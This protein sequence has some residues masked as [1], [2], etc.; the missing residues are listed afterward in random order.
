MLAQ[1]R[2]I[3][4][5]SLLA[6]ALVFIFSCKSALTPEPNSKTIGQIAADKLGKFNSYPSPSATNS[7]YVQ[8]APETPAAGILKFVVIEIESQTI[9]YEGSFMPGYVKWL[10]NYSLEVLDYPR[11]P[12][13]NEDPAHYKKVINLKAIH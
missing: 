3:S 5:V 4:V 9:L 11:M 13:E 2:K 6:G 8:Q 7:L 10:D 1:W 12:K